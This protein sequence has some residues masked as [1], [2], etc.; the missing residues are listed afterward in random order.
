MHRTADNPP[1][2]DQLISIS[3][4]SLLH[5]IGR[6]SVSLARDLAVQHHC[7]LKRV[8][9]SRH[10]KIVGEFSQP[11]LFKKALISEDAILYQFLLTKITV[12]LANID[13]PLTLDQQLAQLIAAYPL[14][15]LAE[16]MHIT[17]CSEAEARLA[18][19]KN[20]TL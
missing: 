2:S 4:P 13:P 9:R 5:R 8:R 1:M 3:L 7:E 6:S 10:W 11:E 16:L 17:Q 15:T 19:F 20:E 14:M 12:A 18:R